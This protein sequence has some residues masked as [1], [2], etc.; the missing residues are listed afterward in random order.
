MNWLVTDTVDGCEIDSWSI[1]FF[2]AFN[3]YYYP[4]IS[5]VMQDFATI[6]RVSLRPCF[7]KPGVAPAPWKRGRSG[8]KHGESRARPGERRPLMGQSC[9]ARV[10][11]LLFFVEVGSHLFSSPRKKSMTLQCLD[12]LL[13]LLYHISWVIHGEILLK[14]QLGIQSGSM[15]YRSVTKKSANSMAQENPK[16]LMLPAFIAASTPGDFPFPKGTL[17]LCQA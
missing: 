11:A 8:S 12:G 15:G 14:S 9:W 4:I 5:T 2:K 3:H 10:A 1:P 13:V 6:H 7:T 17:W 16:G